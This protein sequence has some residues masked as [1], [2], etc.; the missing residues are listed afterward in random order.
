M[1]DFGSGDGDVAVMKG[2]VLGLAPGR[3]LIDISHDIAP[4][5]IS[6]AAWVL[7]S[8]YRYFPRG[9][10][11]VCVVDP[12]VGSRRLPIALHAGEWF[13]VGPNNGL[14]SYILQEQPVHEVVAITNPAYHLA[15]VSA[16]FHGRDIF[17]P[18]AAHIA[19]S[20]PLADL[21][22]AVQLSALQQLNIAP[23]L[24]S[25]GRISAQIVHVDHFGNLITNIPASML[26]DFFVY[27]RVQLLFSDT[28]R[29]VS[30]RRRF[31]SDAADEVGDEQLP[32]LYSD[33]SGYIGV[34]LQNGNAARLLQASTRAPVVFTYS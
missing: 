20:V 4:Q 23:T 1:T 5:D 12:G 11:F 17:S 8:G 24:L 29:I 7:A 30:A 3:T 16:T 10:I 26:P 34:A 25:D 28:G 2:V 32:F 15:Q 22:P 27:D 19:N 6:S 31:F 33:S 14:F 21:G 18:V 9:T 13:F